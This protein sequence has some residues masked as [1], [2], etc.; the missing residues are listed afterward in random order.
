MQIKFQSRFESSLT[1]R[2]QISKERL[3]LFSCHFLRPALRPYVPALRL[4][5]MAP[6]AGKMARATW[7][8]PCRNC[9]RIYRN[10]A[11]TWITIESHESAASDLA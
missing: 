5:I 4:G 3:L 2:N 10:V 9:A 7:P 1:A 8:P 6:P 11:S